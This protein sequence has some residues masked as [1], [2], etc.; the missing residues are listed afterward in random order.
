MWIYQ[1]PLLF[2]EYLMFD[3]GIVST[4]AYLQQQLSLAG[5]VYQ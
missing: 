3:L 5:A 1:W 2:S 4:A